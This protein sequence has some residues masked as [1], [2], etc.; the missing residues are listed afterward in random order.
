MTVCSLTRG[1]SRDDFSDIYEN[2]QTRVQ[3]LVWIDKLTYI[4]P[5]GWCFL[6]T[7][8]F[9]FT[10]WVWWVSVFP[11]LEQ[12]DIVTALDLFCF[13]PCISLLSDCLFLCAMLGL[14]SSLCLGYCVILWISSSCS[15]PFSPSNSVCSVIQLISCSPL[16]QNFHFL[17]K[18]WLPSAGKHW[19]HVHKRQILLSAQYRLSSAAVGQ[20]L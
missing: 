7:L 5:S 8:M 12:C 3:N 15:F 17:G 16:C 18:Q 1:D 20:L 6:I 2:H 14:L 4:L 11:C 9:S 19:F 13:Q 10:K